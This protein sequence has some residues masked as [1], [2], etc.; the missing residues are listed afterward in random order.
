MKKR[1]IILILAFVIISAI[2]FFAT[3][4]E[5]AHFARITKDGK[6]YSVVSLYG[7]TEIRIG[8]T[9]VAEVKDGKIFMKSA[10]CPDKLCIHQGE[11]YDSSKKIV[12]LPNKIVI[13]A[14][15]GSDID[16]VVK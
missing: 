2:L 5:S 14:I 6:L 11:I 9:N 13:E 8:D 3:P 4:G 15:A 16:T 7:N 10:T 12:C 1:D